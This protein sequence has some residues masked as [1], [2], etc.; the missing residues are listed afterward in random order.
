MI[1]YPIIPSLGETFPLPFAQMHVAASP[2]QGGVVPCVSC[3]KTDL[4][5]DRFER[6]IISGKN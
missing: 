2:V 4:Q 5:F 6:Y 3:A 1:E